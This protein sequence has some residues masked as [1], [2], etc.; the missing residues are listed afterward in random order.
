MVEFSKLTVFRFTALVQR[1]S[2]ASQS[3]MLVLKDS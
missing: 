1:S 2:V 3:S